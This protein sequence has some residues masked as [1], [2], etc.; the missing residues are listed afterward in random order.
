MIERRE[1]LISKKRLSPMKDIHS[2]CFPM[3][4][5]LLDTCVSVGK[6]R[7]RF[8]PMSTL[9]VDTCVPSGRCS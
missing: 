5:L 6:C 1:K 7:S 4:T 2:L 9:L 8:P 3:S